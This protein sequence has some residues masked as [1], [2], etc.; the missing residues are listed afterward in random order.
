MA[1]ISQSNLLPVRPVD[2][3]KEH[4]KMGD[5]FPRLEFRSI[6]GCKPESVYPF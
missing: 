6:S 2:T 5:M 1:L 3:D 4:A